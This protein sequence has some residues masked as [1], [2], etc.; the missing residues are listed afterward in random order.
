MKFF[1]AFVLLIIFSSCNNEKEK[2]PA[3][4]IISKAIEKAGGEKYEKAEIHFKF[5]KNT[6][7]SR[8]DGGLFEYTRTI[9]DTLGEARDVLTNEGFRRFREEQE[10]TLHDTLKSAFSNSVNSVH[11]F[12]QLPYGLNAP[13]VQEELVG[14]DTISGEPY[15]E[16]K[17]TFAQ[18]GGGTDHE[19]E[20]MYWIH[21][22]DYT[23][24]YLA[25]RFYVNEGGI[26][27][28][29]AINPRKIEGLRFVDYENYKLQD[30]WE[31]IDLKD[32]DELFEAGK[33]PLLSLIETQ[34]EKVEIQE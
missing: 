34:I 26:R 19:D 4:N 14:E 1:Y 5:R 16:I 13:A 32:L 6:F 25:Y 8:R 28:R 2:T 30:N 11:Y 18:E 33:L 29:K 12:V 21:Q 31:N 27:F 17:V 9:T 23:V 20:Y 10:E 15:F 3:E 24:D 7:S 22:E